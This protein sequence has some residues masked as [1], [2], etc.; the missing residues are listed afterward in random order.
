MHCLSESSKFLNFQNY[1]RRKLIELNRVAKHSLTFQRKSDSYAKLLSVIPWIRYLFPEKCDYNVLLKS[2]QG[3]YKFMKRF[4]D[5]QID[6]YDENHQRHFL[7]MYITEMRKSEKSNDFSGGFFCKCSFDII[8]LNF[9]QSRHI[10]LKIEGQ[11][12]PIFSF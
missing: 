6:T 9:Y 10:A 12:F 8:Y 2:N 11:K 5:K 1:N 3:L 4:V 7:D